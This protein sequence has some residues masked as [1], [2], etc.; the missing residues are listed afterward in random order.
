MRSTEVA[1]SKLKAFS[2]HALVAAAKDSATRAFAAFISSPGTSHAGACVFCSAFATQGPGQLVSSMHTIIQNIEALPTKQQAPALR[3][4]L[5]CNRL[6]VTHLPNDFL[7][8]R[9]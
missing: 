4:M 6:G 9:Y 5:T 7:D 1:T 2:L 3:L 8:G